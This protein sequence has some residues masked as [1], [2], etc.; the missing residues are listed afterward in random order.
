LTGYT[1]RTGYT[2]TTGYSGETWY[3][4]QTGYTGQTGYFGQTGY[5]GPSCTTHSQSSSDLAS[6]SSSNGSGTGQIWKG[7]K[8]WNESTLHAHF[9]PTFCP[10]LKFGTFCRYGSTVRSFL[11]F[12]HYTQP[13]RAC[14]FPSQCSKRTGE[15]IAFFEEEASARSLLH[16]RSTSVPSGSCSPSPFTSTCGRNFRPTSPTTTNTSQFATGDY[17]DYTPSTHTQTQTS[18]TGTYTAAH[19]QGSYT[20]T[21]S[22]QSLRRL[23]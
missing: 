8:G 23:R 18:I 16:A 13:H 12:T 3:S 21:T 7:I 6:Y 1:S 4:E 9:V 17:R 11:P 14:Y 22:S 15:P 5:T 2:G 20:S 10:E 19:S